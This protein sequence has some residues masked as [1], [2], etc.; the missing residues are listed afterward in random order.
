MYCVEGAYPC[1]RNLD[2]GWEVGV[3]D[4]WVEDSCAL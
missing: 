4:D 1:W 3:F 2:A